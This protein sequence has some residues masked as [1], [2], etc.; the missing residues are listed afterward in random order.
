MFQAAEDRAPAVVLLEDI[1][2]AF[3]P[4]ASGRRRGRISGQQLLNCLDGLSTQHGIV[5][6]G[7]ANDP[8]TLDSAI[9]R[10][11]G[12]FDRLAAFPLPSLA[13]RSEY[14]RRLAGDEL[15]EQS[16]LTVAREAD[17]LSYAQLREAYILSGQRSFCD[18]NSV[19]A[20]DILS[21]IRTVKMEAI[22]V[23]TKGDGKSLGFEP[24][25]LT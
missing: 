8:S 2:R 23:G 22:N 25:Q 10:R 6:V 14:L 17:R 3:G 21:A 4:E 7:T 19:Q 18:G 15:D 12:R 16:R 5:V 20:E 9:V 11:P 1:D 13:L 24:T